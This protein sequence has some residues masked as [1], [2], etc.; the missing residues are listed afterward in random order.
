MA[1]KTKRQIEQE[2]RE[3]SMISEARRKGENI[4]YIDDDGCE[5]TVT[6]GGHV[7]YN[8]SDWY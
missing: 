3:R 5:V 1:E 7:F 4:S 8:A 6:T 2:R